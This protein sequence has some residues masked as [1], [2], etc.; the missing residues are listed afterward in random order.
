MAMLTLLGRPFVWVWR[1]IGLKWLPAKARLP[2]GLVL[3]YG[4]TA[5]LL[6]DRLSPQPV[7]QADMGDEY[8]HNAVLTKDG[9]TVLATCTATRGSVKALAVV[10][11]RRTSA[12]NPAEASVYA[13]AHNLV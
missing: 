4:A 8:I 7:W 9:H 12:P 1:A 3:L 6:W 5:A 10:G 2:L 11:W 13:V